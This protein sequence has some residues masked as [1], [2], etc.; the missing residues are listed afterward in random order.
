[1]IG[2]NAHLNDDRLLECYLGERGIEPINFRAAEH[3]DE[4]ARCRDRYA[5]LVDTMDEL[6]VNAGVETDA[7]FTPERLDTQRQLIARRLAAINHA[8]RVLAFPGQTQTS[9]SA[10][11]RFAP[12]WL[13]AAAA[14]GLFVGVGVGVFFDARARGFRPTVATVMPV[15]APVQAPGVPGAQVQPAAAPKPDA[16]PAPVTN[17]SDPDTS[18]DD[19]AFMAELQAAFERPGARE[20]MALDALT[21]RVRDI[22]YS[23]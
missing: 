10:G 17:V 2:W 1:V 16:A 5:A 11:I 8:A 12:R 23:R 19:S 18:D 22:S 7:V 4:C 13:A 14:A 20:L 3:L 15:S 21:P 9:S 6:Y